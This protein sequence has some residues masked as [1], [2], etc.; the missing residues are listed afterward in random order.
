MTDTKTLHPQIDVFPACT[1]CGV[2]YVLRRGLIMNMGTGD[3]RVDWAWQKDCR[4]KT[5][6][7]KAPAELIDADGTAYP[8]QSPDGAE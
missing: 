6:C 2:A 5:P 7:K 3:L 4:P 1:N 8:G